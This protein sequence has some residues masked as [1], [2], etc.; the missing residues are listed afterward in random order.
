MTFKIEHIY[1]NIK[2]H[3]AQNSQ[4][5]A[6]NVFCFLKFHRWCCEVF[7]SLHQLKVFCSRSIATTLLQCN[8]DT[9]SLTHCEGAL[10]Y[11]AGCSPRDPSPCRSCRT[12]LRAW[13]CC[14]RITLGCPRSQTYTTCSACRISMLAMHKTLNLNPFFPQRLV[15]PWW[16]SF[17]AT[18]WTG[19]TT[20]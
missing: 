10:I 1:Y 20:V 15:T 14:Y 8:I 4:P 19:R 6:T 7:F 5:K 18:P 2:E 3:F 16:T 17:G 11:F 13:S 12:W 9:L